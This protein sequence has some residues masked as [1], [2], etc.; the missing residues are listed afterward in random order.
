MLVCFTYKSA[1]DATQLQNLHTWAVVHETSRPASPTRLSYYGQK[2]FA[3]VTGVRLPLPSYAHHSA[4]YGR[5]TEENGFLNK[6][7]K[8]LC[9]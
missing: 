9:L 7:Q 3:L 1:N 8:T 2:V 6:R 5:A 4:I